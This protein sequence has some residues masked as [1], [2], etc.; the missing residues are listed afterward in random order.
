MENWM[1]QVSAAYAEAN[2]LEDHSFVLNEE[3]RD[4]EADAKAARDCTY[5]EA[6]L[7]RTEE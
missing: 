5:T 7:R 1:K 2:D 6:M 3:D 4:Y